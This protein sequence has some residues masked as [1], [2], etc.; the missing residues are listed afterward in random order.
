MERRLSIR[1]PNA[2]LDGRYG[3]MKRKIKEWWNKPRFT[4]LEFI[5]LAWVIG[6]TLGM[7][8]FGIIIML[9]KL[10]TS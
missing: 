7:I 1:Q 4:E 8:F 2:E 6:T 3:A 10:V 9:I 5:F